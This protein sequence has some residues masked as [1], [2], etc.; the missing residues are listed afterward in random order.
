MGPPCCRAAATLTGT[1]CLQT[2]GCT[3]CKEVPA[4]RNWDR[5]A[6]NVGVARAMLLHT[7]LPGG[8][9]RAGS[10]VAAHLSCALH[11]LHRDLPPKRDWNK[12]V[13]GS[14]DGC[15]GC[16]P[17]AW[18]FYGFL[19]VFYGKMQRKAENSAATSNLNLK[20]LNYVVTWTAPPYTTPT[21]RRARQAREY[22]AL[23]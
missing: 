15:G 10:A 20:F 4:V 3:N 21:P 11:S 8:L 22:A 17:P 18:P 16:Y 6:F 1:L 19:L 14:K 23:P 12:H 9:P 13:K 2:Q 5:S 7:V